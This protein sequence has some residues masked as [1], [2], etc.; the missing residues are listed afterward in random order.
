LRQKSC[1]GLV[2]KLSALRDPLNRSVA[3]PNRAAIL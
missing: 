3:T 2:I 1:G